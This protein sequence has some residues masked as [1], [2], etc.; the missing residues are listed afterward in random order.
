M[1]AVQVV[2]ELTMHML[3]LLQKR[4]QVERHDVIEQLTHFI[5]KREQVL[6]KLSPPY[7]QDEIKI[8]RKIISL[9]KTIEQEMNALFTELKQD[10]KQTKRQRK[11]TQSYVNPY[12]SVQTIDGMFMDQKK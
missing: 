1:Q 5:E 9:N 6:R 4:H 3:H 10:M 11:S 8:G 12:R 2:Y 7:S